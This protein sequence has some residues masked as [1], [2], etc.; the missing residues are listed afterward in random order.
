MNLDI[1][2]SV[3]PA[4]MPIAAL[5]VARAFVRFM[6][7]GFIVA[8]AALVVG[9]TAGPA[10][11]DS[12]TAAVAGGADPGFLVLAPDR[13]FQGNE[14]TREAFETFSAGRNAALVFVTDERTRDS[15]RA[16]LQSL[17]Q[18]GARRL[19]A[20]PLFV[21]SA[22]ARLEL[23]RR[24]LDEVGGR[25]GASHSPGVSVTLARPFGESYLAVEALADRFRNIK[26]RTG[27]RLVVAGYGA[28]DGE[29]RKRMEADL[30]RIAESAADGFGF[31]SV[32]AVVWHERSV[33]ERDARW[34]EAERSLADAA[35]A[36]AVIVPFHLGSKL[37]SMMSFNA[38][39]G[40]IAPRGSA[41]AAEEA[42]T[43]SVLAM[44]MQREARRHEALEPRDIGVVFLAHGADYHWNETMRQ[45]ARPLEQRYKIEYCFSM[46]DQ[47]LVE[48]AVRRLEARGAKA[49]VIV[50]VF[51]LESSFQSNIERM[52]GFDV[53]QASPS[54]AAGK[55]DHRHQEHES[56]H[57]HGAGHGHASGDRD[58][59]PARIRSAAPITTVGG[60]EAD[61]LF[62][63]ALLDRARELSRDPRRET[64]IL[65]AH[66]A[67]E[68]AEN[69]HWLKVLDALASQMRVNG[70][71]E[72][73]AIHYATWREDWPDKRAAWISKV[74]D[75][76][77]EASR[78]GGRAL[79]IPTRTT[80]R[81]SEQTFLAGLSFELGSGFAPHPLFARWLEEKINAGAALRLSAP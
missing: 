61:S 23:A 25:G 13:G 8:C 54:A 22:S 14:E 6:R 42:A 5:R 44:W 41:L 33:P 77:R 26:E 60:I 28:K 38:Y 52:I 76:V 19:V 56:G 46:A 1:S 59:P 58:G 24:L 65:V 80:A 30:R 20:L 40:R 18:N 50:R 43:P 45:A 67:R 9:A 35:G 21:S 11:A 66:G 71:A 64:V 4:R 57:D 32:D 3:P 29:T 53:E 49:I 34:K 51:G 37:D 63:A 81:G 2:H 31:G 74:Q 62:A 36:G 16:A 10:R 15:L 12:S 73:R 17:T 79:V 27:R 72:F 69:E 39:L 7:Q 70:G 78:D 47:P 75:M 55:I 48:R 68:D